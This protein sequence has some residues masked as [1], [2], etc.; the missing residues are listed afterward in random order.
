MSNI[1][2]LWF[3]R[4]RKHRVIS[5]WWEGFRREVS[6]ISQ[7]TT[8]MLPAEQNTIYSNSEKEQY[9]Q[10]LTLIK[11]TKEINSKFDIIYNES[12]A[13]NFEVSWKEII[14]P[15]AILMNDQHGKF[16]K[17]YFQ[18]AFYENKFNILFT[19]YR[20]ATIKFHP[21]LIKKF[22]W[23][24]LPFAIDPEIFKDY[25]QFKKINCLN[26]GIINPQVY[27]LRFK[28]HKELQSLNG[29]TRIE[30]PPEKFIGNKWPIGKEYANILNSA[31]ITITDSSIY[32]YPVLK[33][34]EIPACKSVLCSD[35]FG[36]LKDL[37][38]IP[39]ENM[40]LIKKTDDIK[41]TISKALKNPKLEKIANSGYSLMHNNH[42]LQIRA[43]EFIRS[44]ESL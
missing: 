20:D 29:Y 25:N 14:I 6:K 5:H 43:Q 1:K 3:T 21:D 17:E 32:K 33:F 2:I 37:G 39:N 13:A 34:F 44:I 7:V 16:V 31:K 42:T 28:A 22:T 10:Q 24:W 9:N 23:F 38:L 18:R 41:E 8:I 35:Y 30:R 4:S 12:P 36:E 40:I 11:D 15:K 19:T 27:P 26:V